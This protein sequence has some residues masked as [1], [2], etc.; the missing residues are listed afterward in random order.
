MTETPGV[1]QRLRDEMAAHGFVGPVNQI[2]YCL[3][4]AEPA[5]YD[6]A[7]EGVICPN[8]AEHRVGRLEVVSAIEALELARQRNGA[9]QQLAEVRKVLDSE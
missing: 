3:I 4:C 6:P 5:I 1:D 7:I 8:D 9:V 2:D